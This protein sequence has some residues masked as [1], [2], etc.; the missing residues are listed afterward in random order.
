VKH[1][2]R[3]LLRENS[4]LREARYPLPRRL[5]GRLLVNR[6]IGQ[7][8]VAYA[9][10]L[11]TAL[12]I[13]WAGNRYFPE[14]L[15]GYYG[16]GA[17]DFLKDVASYL[18]AAQIG[19]LAIVSV[20]VAVVTLLS[21]RND[22]SA[23]NT[24]IRLYYFESYSYELA[25]SGVALLIVL[26]LQLF[27][28]LQ[29]LLH[30]AGL[31]GR[32]YAF[33]LAMT[34]LH[35]LWF[36]FNLFLFLQFI[37]TTL[38]FVEPSTRER[39]RERYS[40]NEIIPRDVERRLMRALYYSAPTQTFGKDVLS[41][42]PNIAFGYSLGLGDAPTPEVVTIFRGTRQLYDVRLGP[43]EWVLRRWHGRIRSSPRQRQRF[44]EPSW[45]GQLSITANFDDGLSGRREW[46]LRRDGVPLG[47]F[48]KWVIR[49][50]FRF[51]RARPRDTDMPVPENF[52]EQLVDKVVRQI[53]QAA[54]TGFRAAL[55]EAIQY[56]RFILAA[57]N[58]KDD[59]GHAF[60]LAE[61]GDF[62]T[63]PD[64][65][66]VDQ[67]RRAFSAGAD[68]IGADT[69]FMNR[70]GNLAARLIPDDAVNFSPRVLQALLILGIYEVNALEDWVTKRAVL[71][72]PDLEVG[73][74]TALS[75]SDK[76]AYEDILVSFEGSWETAL[77][78]LIA[79]F[80]LERRPASAVSVDG[81]RVF[82]ASFPVLQTHLHNTA[83]FFAAS[84]WN[85]DPLGAD[86]FR[87]LLVRWVQPF[88]ANLQSSYVFSN[89]FLFTPDMIEQEWPHAQA[90]VAR[91]VQ[92]PQEQVQ[93][94]PVS[95]ILLWELHADVICVG[96]LVALHW[97]AT[98]QQPSETASLAAR[99][100]LNRELLA[101]GG[102]TLTAMQPKSTFRL[103]LEFSIRYALN[104]RFAEARYSAT[105]D[106]LVRYL[107]NLASPRMVSGRIYGGFGIEGV[108]TLRTALLGAMAATLPPRGDGG[109]TTLMEEL[110]SDILF[111]QDKAVR[112][113]IWTMQQMAQSL[114]AAQGSEPY[115][116]AAH[117][118]NP[119][120]D[121][122]VA[123]ERL[124]G[125]LGVPVNV[126]ETLRK[127]RLRN[128]PLDESRMEAVRRHITE[129]VLAYGPSITCFQ[130]YPIRRQ[131]SGQVIT[132]EHEFG[133]IDKGSFVTPEMSAL[134][135]TDLPPLFAE[136]S[137]NYLTN[138]LWHGLYH[139]PKRVVTVDVSRGRELFWNRVIEEAAGVG[140]APIVIVP[141]DGFGEDISHATMRLSGGGL[142][143]F[144]VSHVP[145]MP[146][147]GGAGYLGTI[148]GVHVYTSSI[149]ENQAVLCSSQI[150]RAIEYGIVHGE[151]DIVDLWFL[152][153]EDLTKSNVKLKFAQKI[154]WADSPIV[155][156][157]FAGQESC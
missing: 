48:E 145:G 80:G 109:V 92:F 132:T 154:D 69:S 120:V 85:D 127:D 55:T 35:A 14:W 76:R 21:E 124:R 66:W 104:P 90:Y 1:E 136:V 147:G 112:T 155:E 43:L 107:T 115:V 37:T 10:I 29:H 151:G 144:E 95:G 3:N 141:Y 96:G 135:F 82:T 91:H 134:T 133:Q 156:F 31:G 63:R 114:E 149:M 77:Q 52:L 16:S 19:I 142:P 27:W 130:G 17:R 57:Q 72:S 6:S 153:A 39:L 98:Q 34:G 56:H 42:G 50:C 87:D 20:A 126:F 71:G 22:G 148:N 121:I 65:V 128:A 38:R 12:V 139:R 58:T 89:T 2:L 146:S 157:Q 152:D 44:G 138:L 33:K 45:N 60:N 84:V 93:S 13:E 40:A 129:A 25:I 51:A 74:S 59:A 24:D 41:E 26:T 125:I 140:P 49:R 68:K 62:F 137:R 8:L 15:P 100:M 70:L 131:Q 9:L 47:S 61:V 113:F 116:K 7:F 99:R 46:V 30:M 150:I 64:V 118:I 75:G 86:H 111:E 78:T 105:M 67:Y 143:G 110:K 122:P 102:S 101:S 79:S 97:Y 28:P 4:T 73:A 53:D 106:G 54:A 23:V 18:I 32:D 123:T 11:L 36:T 83:Y 117:A 94:G 5:L 103:L 81:W 108:D 88:Y 119:E